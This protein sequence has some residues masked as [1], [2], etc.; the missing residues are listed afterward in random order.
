MTQ[1]HSLA[2]FKTENP[3][4]AAATGLQSRRQVVCP[5]S[6]I[7][8]R[9]RI[10]GTISGSGPLT[11]R[12][13]VE[14]KISIKGR[15]S[16]APEG[17]V[18]ADIEADGVQVQGHLQGMVRAHE[19]VRILPPGRLEGDTLCPQAQVALGAIVRGGLLIRAP[20]RRSGL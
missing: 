1:S 17:R 18:Q 16:L 9:T 6:I 11:I 8:P 12:G 19:W 7:G 13:S 2:L 10:Y 20:R 14:G 3:N 4:Q 5:P 15:L